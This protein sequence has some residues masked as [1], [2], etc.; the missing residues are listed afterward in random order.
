VAKPE[1]KGPPGG[2]GRRWEDNIKTNHTKIGWS[3]MDWIDLAQVR[4]R[5]GDLVSTVMNLWVPVTS[6]TVLIVVIHFIY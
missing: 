3:D 6:R 5:C 2:P 1:G 4:D